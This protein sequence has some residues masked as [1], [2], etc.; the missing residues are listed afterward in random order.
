M[1]SKIKKEANSGETKKLKVNSKDNI[2]KVVSQDKKTV[3]TGNKSNSVRKKPVVRKVVQEETDTKSKAVK[4]K[5]AKPVKK[6]VVTS[7]KSA[8]KT[9]K[10]A[11]GAKKKAIKPVKKT[12][13]KKK[14]EPVVEE[15][16]NEIKEEPIVEETKEVVSEIKEEVQE[17]IKETVEEVKPEEPESILETFKDNKEEE[18]KEEQ[19]VIKEEKKKVGINKSKLSIPGSRKEAISLSKNKK[20]KKQVKKLPVPEKNV[21]SIIKPVEEKPKEVVPVLE[22][23]KG[24]ETEIKAIKTENIENIKKR[25]KKNK[26][27]TVTKVKPKEPALTGK[28]VKSVYD[29]KLNRWVVKE[30][31]SK[32]APGKKTKLSNVPIDGNDYTYELETGGLKSKF[33]EEVN[34]ER[35][36]EAKKQKRRKYPK[37]ILIT[38]LILIILGSAGFIFYKKYQDKIKHD[39]NMYDVYY[40]GQQVKLSDDSIW[41]IVDLSD[42]SKADVTLLSNTVIDTNGD[43]QITDADRMQFSSGST[44]YDILDNTSIAYFLENQYKQ[45]IE[46]KVGEI[47][48]I[49]LMESKQFVK[50]RDTLQYG[51]EWDGENILTSNTMYYYYLATSQNEKMYIVNRRGSYKMVKPTDKYYVRIVINVDKSLIKKD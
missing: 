4:K 27:P 48:S 22:I 19:P 50:I 14:V 20:N 45:K 28:R 49:S 39:L 18:K 40:L 29:P 2:E 11:T 41:Y 44:K 21:K 31:K 33:F 38:L 37:R 32:P 3:V 6:T 23:E 36:K 13:A 1:A 7:A 25:A 5:I 43:G 10:S 17:E 16:K 12:T 46:E 30:D 35:F 51:Y 15:V 9:I 34:V 42:G 26:K 47:N 24:Q 8:E